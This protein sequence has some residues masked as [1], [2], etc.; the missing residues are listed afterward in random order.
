MSK[1]ATQRNC[2]SASLNKNG[3]SI[4]EILVALGIMSVIA[5]GM[6]TTFSQQQQEVRALGEKF[7]TQSLSHS[8]LTM[9]QSPASCRANFIYGVVPT[10]ISDATTSSPSAHSIDIPEL[11]VGLTPTTALIAKT[12]QSL[13]GKPV[14][15]MVV[16]SIKIKDITKTGVL[17]EYK[18]SLTIEFDPTSLARSLRPVSIDQIFTIITP[19]NAAIVNNCGS[20]GASVPVASTIIEPKCEWNAMAGLGVCTPPTC[21]VG[22]TDLGI[23]SRS[24]QA[25]INNPGSPTVGYTSRYCV[26]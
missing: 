12:G 6:A 21:P 3:F 10:D 14:G 8:V 4:I 2:N 9:I 20:I 5:T 25:V 1:K 24:P 22:W 16:L 13:P 11:H 26:Q 18:G 17:N 7:D 19:D 23:T 15:R